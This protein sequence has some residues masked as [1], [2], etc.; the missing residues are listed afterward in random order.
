MK[1][2]SYYIAFTHRYNAK[3]NGEFQNRQWGMRFSKGVNF[4][5]KAIV[6]PWHLVPRQ[7]QVISI[8]TMAS[9]IFYIYSIFNQSSVAQFSTTTDPPRWWHHLVAGTFSECLSMIGSSG[10]AGLSSG[11]C[12]SLTPIRSHKKCDLIFIC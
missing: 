10:A 3:K 2:T 12:Q 8:Y 4:V 6:Y 1:I 5:R 7:V 9:N 11:A